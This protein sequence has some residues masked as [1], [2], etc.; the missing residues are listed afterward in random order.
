MFPEG[1]WGRV[2]GIGGEKFD[3]FGVMLSIRN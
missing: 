3:V 1:D 2:P